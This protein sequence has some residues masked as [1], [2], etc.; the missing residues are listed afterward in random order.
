M[1][2][3]IDHIIVALPEEA[4]MTETTENAFD[5]TYL[6]RLPIAMAYVPYQRWCGTYDACRALERGTIFP[7]LDLPF[8]GRELV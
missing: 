8:C 3:Y 2:N 5:S 4:G 6:G 7:E 1:E